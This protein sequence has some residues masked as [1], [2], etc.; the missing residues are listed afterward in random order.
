MS[1]KN[2]YDLSV[3]TCSRCGLIYK[4][5]TIKEG[6]PC[7]REGCSG[8]IANCPALLLYAMKSLYKKGLVAEPCCEFPWESADNWAAGISLTFPD[9]YRSHFKGLPYGFDIMEL[10]NENEGKR[11]IVLYWKSFEVKP[12]TA[13]GQLLKAAANLLEWA[14]KSVA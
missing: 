4:K 1:G 9:D 7:S 6:D 2:M 8:V 5:G 13:F 3:L 12:E 11:R 14:E 10:A